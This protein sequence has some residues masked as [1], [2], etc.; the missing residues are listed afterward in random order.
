MRW[1]MI[2]TKIISVL[3]LLLLKAVI[4]S[5][6]WLGNIQ[7]LK[8]CGI[9]ILVLRQKFMFLFYLQVVDVR[10]LEMLLQVFNLGVQRNAEHVDFLQILIAAGPHWSEEG[11]VKTE[12]ARAGKDHHYFKR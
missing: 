12:R 6:T 5:A 9:D 3:S 10:R 4:G 7:E 8:S 2:L 11:D 1:W